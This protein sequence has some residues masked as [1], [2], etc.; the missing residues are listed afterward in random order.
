MNTNDIA[1]MM[2]LSCVQASST[3]DE[4]QEA[5]ALA[6]AY[7]VLAVFVLPAHMPHLIELIGDSD[8]LPAATVGFPSG[9]ATTAGKVAEGVGI[10]ISSLLSGDKQYRSN[11]IPIRNLEK[12]GEDYALPKHCRPQPF[13][14]APDTPGSI[15]AVLPG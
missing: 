8:I 6:K 11:V 3:L 12:T 7:D 10:N 13:W 4:M 2:D 14:L 15:R 5:V 9:A 1:K